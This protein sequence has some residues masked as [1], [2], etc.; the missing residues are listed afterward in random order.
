MTK[1]SAA[2]V[3]CA[4]CGVC[5]E[6]RGLSHKSVCTCMNGA[7]LLPSQEFPCNLHI[8]SHGRESHFG[9]LIFVKLGVVWEIRRSGADMLYTYT[10]GTAECHGV[11]QA[12]CGPLIFR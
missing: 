1:R 11:W 2:S 4:L 7:C 8:N 5:V 6:M 3:L 9:A 12:V 10:H